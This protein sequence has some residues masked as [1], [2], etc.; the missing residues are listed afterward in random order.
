MRRACVEVNQQQHCE[1][2]WEKQVSKRTNNNVYT[3][4]KQQC[5][6]DKILENAVTQTFYFKDV[7]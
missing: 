5:G 6:G 2:E 3:L 4:H 1:R 7:R